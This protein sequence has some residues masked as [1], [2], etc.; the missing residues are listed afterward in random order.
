MAKIDQER[1]VR[2]FLELVQINAL[3][4]QERPVAD[5][6]IQ[7][8]E[9]WGLP[10]V[11]DTAGDQIDGNCGNLIVTVN[12][13]GPPQFFMCAHMDTVRPTAALKPRIADG[14]IRSDGTTILGA[15]NRGGDT[16]L[17]YLLEEA[18]R[19]RIPHQSFEVIFTV[20][21]E[22]GLEGAAHLDWAHVHSNMGYIFD[23]SRPPGEYIAETP[24]AV[25]LT[26]DFK[27]KPAH[28]GVSPEKGIN[29]LRMAT[30]VLQEFPVGHVDSETVA[31]I[32][33]IRGGDATNVVPAHVHVE[34]EIR[35]LRESTIAELL[36]N[37]QASLERAALEIG[38]A[39]QLHHDT[40]FKG[41]RIPKDHKLIHR[42]QIKMRQVGLEPSPLV[43]SGG[44][45]ANV[46]N[47]IGKT[48]INLGVGQQNPHAN[49]ECILIEDLIK[50]TELAL[51]LVEPE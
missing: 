48:A 43:Y 34:G 47:A 49:D 13:A 37:L 22:I 8:L 19:G 2:T 35:S 4:R 15:D 45:D 5:Y 42:L 29:A 41:F 3:S 30:Q 50:T 16:V 44:S 38:G 1:L 14:V 26:I 51:A 24:S 36:E 39:Y 40:H 21:E 46:F 27:G 18:A 31:N 33:I 28:A 23:S 12:G 17:L 32:G 6:I 11:E 10:Y 20:A 7:K 9:A 25:G